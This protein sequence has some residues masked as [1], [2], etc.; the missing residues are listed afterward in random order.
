MSVIGA[1]GSGGGF[2]QDP[3]T[4]KVLSR[5]IVRCGSRVDGIQCV[6][7]D[8]S[9]TSSHGGTGGREEFFNLSPNEAI[10]VNKIYNAVRIFTHLSQTVQVWSGSEVDA[11]QFQTT[12]GRWSPKYGGSGGAPYIIRGN[13]NQKE[14]ALMGFKGR[15]G[16]RIDYLEVF[17]STESS[18]IT[19]Y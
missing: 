19:C 17:T 16:S 8:G 5:I 2:F 10:L 9:M 12:M 7:T 6:Y 18:S 1:G 11:L 3:T 13:A 15:S 14:R 4:T